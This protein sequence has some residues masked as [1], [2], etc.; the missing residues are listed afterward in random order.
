MKDAFRRSLLGQLLQGM[1]ALFIIAFLFVVCQL[2]AQPNEK[3]GNSL[4]REG[5]FDYDKD[6]LL[7]WHQNV[8]R[9]LMK[10]K[11]KGQPRAKYE[12]KLVRF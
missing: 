3:L 10:G 6:D 9:R 5:K 1:N 7:M 12:P 8:R 11:L 2:D 4:A